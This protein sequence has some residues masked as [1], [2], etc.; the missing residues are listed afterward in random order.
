[1]HH[2]AWPDAIIDHEDRNRENNRISNLR[3]ASVA[4]NSWNANVKSNNKLGIKG[5]AKTRYGKYE[6]RVSAHGKA[7]FLG[8]FSSLREAVAA[9]N[10]ATKT[11]HGEYRPEG[12][13]NPLM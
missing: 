3:A 12:A 2:G 9:H 13:V 6:A 8:S 7:Y 4:Q 1:M 11:L 5:V 10:Q